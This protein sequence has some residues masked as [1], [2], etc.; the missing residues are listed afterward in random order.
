MKKKNLFNMSTIHQ[1]S[2]KLLRPKRKRSYR[3]RVFKKG[4]QRKGVV[5]RAYI[6][7][8]KKPNSAK[9][10]IA[11]VKLSTG[12]YV[13]MY[14]NG[15]SNKVKRYDQILVRSGKAQ[16][17]PGVKFKGVF[18]KYDFRVHTKRTKGLSKLGLKK[19]K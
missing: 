2:I 4:P 9:R 8:P 17:L 16:D 14:I 18:G 5:Q 3:L 6:I 15:E 10:K 13:L 1:I 7:T 19:Q 12:F 11:K